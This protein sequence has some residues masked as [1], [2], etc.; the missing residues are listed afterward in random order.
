MDQD[1]IDTDQI[2]P[3]RHLMMPRDERYGGYVFKD[4]RLDQTKMKLKLCP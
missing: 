1:N 2:L 3:A 4:L